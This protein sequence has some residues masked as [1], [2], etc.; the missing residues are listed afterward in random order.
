MKSQRKQRKCGSAGLPSARDAQAFTRLELAAMLAALGLLALLALPVL[1]NQRGRSARVLCLN[2]LRLA[3]QAFQQWGTEHGGRLPWRT[4]ASELGTMGNPLANNAWFQWSWI[5]NELRTPKILA[6]PSDAPKTAASTWSLS[7]NGGFLYPTYRNKSV[8]YLIGLD[9]FP[10]SPDG[11]VAGDRN[12]R[13]N[14]VGNCSAG[15]TGVPGLASGPAGSFGIGG[16]LHVEAGN[17]LFTDGR[18]E[19]LS[20]EAFVARWLETT[21]ANDDNGSAHYLTP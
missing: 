5:S 13:F 11:L 10:E 4:P 14:L 21:G 6:C 15:L 9:V 18:V 8:S 19:E 2:N 17:Y 1:A 3:G 20:S 7:P 16:G 12:V